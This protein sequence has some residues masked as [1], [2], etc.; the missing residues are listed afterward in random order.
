[1][2]NSIDRVRLKTLA[3][4]QI[5]GSIGVLF[6]CNVIRGLI[7]GGCNAIPLVG[8]I[9]YL[10]LSGP[11]AFGSSL[12]FLKLTKG[13]GVDIGDLFK[14]FNNFA[15][16]VGINLLS[17]ILIFFWCLLLI[18]PGIIK[19]LSYSMA[20][21][22][23]VDNPDFKA[24]QAMEHSERMMDGHKMDLFILELSFIPWGLL[25]VVTFGI[26]GIYVFPYMEATIANFYNEIKNEYANF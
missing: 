7:E 19:S 25:V 26:A 22:V 18:V 11:M 21:Y 6:L 8:P 24:M 13:E 20:M 3:K 16:N 5:R 17:A 10:F 12:I 9:G 23:A 2:E 1:M 4:D 15:T 14:G